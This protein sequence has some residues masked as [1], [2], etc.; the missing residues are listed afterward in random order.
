MCFVILKGYNLI[1]MQ[2]DLEKYSYKN[3]CSVIVM[4]MIM[5]E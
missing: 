5:A 2:I 3:L 4:T 1:N